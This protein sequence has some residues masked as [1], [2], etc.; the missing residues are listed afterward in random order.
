MKLHSI[1]LHINF[2][3]N[4]GIPSQIDALELALKLLAQKGIEINSA[5]TVSGLTNRGSNSSSGRVMGP[6]ESAWLE[7]S[8]N[9]RM[10]CPNGV[11]DRERF[12]KEL[13]QQ[14]KSASASATAAVV[15][16]TDDDA[17]LM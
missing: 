15:S 9:M 11:T 2:N 17:D 7:K 10:R 16:E 3:L 12:A 8:G 6:N 5:E 1:N 4:E 14:S 13:M